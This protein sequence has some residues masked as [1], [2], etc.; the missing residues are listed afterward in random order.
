MKDVETV[1]NTVVEHEGK[2]EATRMYSFYTVK[3]LLDTLRQSTKSYV[4]LVR[5]I[6]YRLTIGRYSVIGYIHK[7]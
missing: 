7:N 1:E 4:R 6:D 5:S 2:L 3:D